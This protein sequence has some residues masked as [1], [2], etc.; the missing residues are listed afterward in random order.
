MTQNENV[1]VICCQPEV[2]DDV[3]FGAH[4]V[5]FQEYVYINL[6]VASFSVS[7]EQSKS[8]IYV[9]RRRWQVHLSPVSGLRS[10]NVK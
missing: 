4:A 7:R 9:M 1:Y 10:K 3:N 2:D 6:W 5:T 8:A